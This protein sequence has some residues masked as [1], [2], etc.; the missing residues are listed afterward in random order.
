MRSLREYIKEDEERLTF[1]KFFLQ[2]SN[3]KSD[4]EKFDFLV[5]SLRNSYEE[6]RAVKSEGNKSSSVYDRFRANLLRNIPKDIVEKATSEA[7]IKTDKQIS[8]KN[9]DEFIEKINSLQDDSL[10]VEALMNKLKEAKENKR[11]SSIRDFLKP[12]KGKIDEA[13]L[14]EVEANEKSSKEYLYF[15]TS[16]ANLNDDEFVSKSIE[17]LKEK[18][19]IKINSFIRTLSNQESRKHLKNILVNELKTDNTGARATA[20]VMRLHT[21]K[22]QNEK[23]TDTGIRVK[24]E[25][26]KEYRKVDIV[27][28][29]DETSNISR[30]TNLKKAIFNGDEKE[31][32]ARL[33]SLI[34]NTNYLK[35]D[36]VFESKRSP[37][38]NVFIEVKNMAGSSEKVDKVL[39]GEVT[40]ITS[41]QFADLAN[42]QKNKELNK[43]LRKLIAA[44]KKAIGDKIDKTIKK[45]LSDSEMYGSRI[46]LAIHDIDADKDNI[47]HVN[48][49]KKVNDLTFKIT[50]TGNI[51]LDIENLKKS[52]LLNRRFLLSKNK[53]KLEESLLELIKCIKS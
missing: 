42:F 52:D 24:S 2:Y 35:N 26:E 18:D 43:A 34:K 23:E 38:K 29:K 46:M 7:G 15:I 11:F 53:E 4:E 25:R 49:R 40:N 20:D 9:N 12:F 39:N 19:R 21:K 22:T 28:E 13:I 31:S 5:K 27:R 33:V 1:S 3:L 8:K 45:Q 41:I 14:K 10:K 30:L 47:F 37:N 48:L 51:T 44:N 17:F 6:Q 50:D 36:V 32:F 16:N